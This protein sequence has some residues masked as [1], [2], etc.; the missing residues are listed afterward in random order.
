MVCF[1]VDELP[2]GSMYAVLVS[3]SP[4]YKLKR[5]DLSERSR[6]KRCCRPV[7]SLSVVTTSHINT[8]ATAEL[9]RL[10]SY[11][12]YSMAFSMVLLKLLLQATVPML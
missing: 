11:S 4:C 10:S 1:Y 8:L 6:L 9:L 7:L 12:S 2:Y 3:G 5:V